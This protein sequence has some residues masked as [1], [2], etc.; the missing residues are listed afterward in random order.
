MLCEFEP[1]KQQVPTGYIRIV[2][3]QFRVARQSGTDCRTEQLSDNLG[4]MT[5]LLGQRERERET[6]GKRREEGE[7][8]RKTEKHKRLRPGMIEAVTTDYFHYR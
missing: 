1:L 5:K 4:R 7:T 2:S 8:C 6:P 3:S